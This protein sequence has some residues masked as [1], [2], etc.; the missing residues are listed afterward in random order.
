MAFP[1][2]FPDGKGDLTNNAV[3]WDTSTNTSQSFAAKLKHLIKFSEKIDGKW[4]YRFASHPRFAYWAYNILYRRRILQQGNFFLKQNP[5]EA[6]LTLSDLKEMLHNQSYTS[7]MSKLLHYTKNVSGTNAYWNSAK[8]DLKSIITQVGAPTIFWTLSCADFHWPEFHNLFSNNGE[9][10]DSER[11]KNVIN[12]PHLLDWFFTERTEQFVKYWLKNALG[13]KWYWFR[14][15]YAVQR[16]SIHCHGVAKLNSDPNLC[17]LSQVALQGHLAAQSLSKDQLS[18]EILL[19]KQQKVTQGLEA[20]KAICN[21][22]DF[23]MSTQNPCNADNWVKPSIHPCKRQFKDIQSN[24]WDKDYEDLLNSVQ[25]HTQCSTAYCLRKRGQDNEVSCRFNFPKECC[26][27]THLQYENFKSKDGAQH[28]KVKVITKRNDSR[29]NN[30]QQIQ[31]QGWRANCDI[32]VIIDYHSCMEYIAKYASKAEK[33]SSVA[34]EAFKSVLC[35]SSNQ[36]ETNRALRTLMMRA[37]GQRDMSIQEVMHQILSIKLVSSTF[38]VITASLDGSCKLNLSKD[39]TLSTETSLLD[40]YAQRKIYEKDFP[41]IS[42]CNFIEFASN[43]CQTKTGI[44]KR[45]S[46]VVIKTYP[47]YSSCLKGPSYGLYCRYQLLRYKPWH[48]SVNNAWDNKEGSD[49]VYIDQWHSFLET[50]KAKTV[51]PNWLQQINSISEYM[52]EIIDND[53]LTESDTGEREEWMI[54]ADLKSKSDAETNILFASETEPYPED[55]TN[56]TIEEIGDMPH[57]INEQ[58]KANIPQQNSTPEPIIQIEQMNDK[59][60]IAFH[61][62]RHHYLSHN[63]NQLLMI[64]TGLGGSGMSFVIEAVRT[65]LN[66][67]CRVCSFFGI[68]AFN[69]KGTTLHSLLQLPIQGKRNGP[70]KSSS[71]AQL[72]HDLKEAKYLIIDEFSVIVRRQLVVLLFHLEG[73]P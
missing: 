32:Q 50:A 49:S 23:L 56:Y 27:K 41:G 26:E 44:K 21:Y 6:N 30:N 65:L 5:S 19:Q 66:E 4:V 3:F 40:S 55:R 42:K 70:L 51:V 16:G 48:H 39:G 57:W 53:D 52:N 2:L 31:L 58:K 36:N 9:I 25:R 34:R 47:N 13:A 61:I 15:E 62:I 68:A 11:R 59:Q 29:L 7:L 22:V 45:T 35:E 73:C 24:E 43:Y 60:R 54:L 18:P 46:P 63:N 28:Y 38:Q 12:N 17:E 69:I 64:I 67:K 8:D 10:L 1:T 20:E 72:Q 71:L 33:I 37:V 14:Y